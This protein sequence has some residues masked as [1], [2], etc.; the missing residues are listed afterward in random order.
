MILKDASA[1]FFVA[2][3]KVTRV[4]KKLTVK[5]QKFADEFLISGNATQAAIHAGYKPKAAHS[6][7]TENLQK[8]AIKDY[9]EKR[10]QELSDAKK[11]DQSEILEYLTKVMRGQ[12]TESVA[13]AK[14]VFEGVEV[15]AKDR[16]KAAELLGKRFGMWKDSVDLTSTNINLTIGG[17]TDGD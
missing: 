5:Q 11:A 10:R 8:P 3:K 16:V 2:R 13:T 12:T 15:G 17:D 7:G 4:V 1:S 6:M 9:I 14:G